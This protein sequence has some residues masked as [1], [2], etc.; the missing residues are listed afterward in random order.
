MGN[1][2]IKPFFIMCVCFL[3]LP[4]FSAFAHDHMPVEKTETVAQIADSVKE[5][6]LGIGPYVIGEFLTAEQAELAYNNLIAD[7]YA[8]T[9]KFFVDD[10]YVI[11]AEKTNMI[12]AIYKQGEDVRADDVKHMV[13]FLMDQF[14]EPTTMAH[15][16]IIYWAFGPD[17]IIAT[18]T[19]DDSKDTGQLD[20]LATVKFNSS[21]AVSPGMSNETVEETGSIYFIITSDLL[22]QKFI[23]Q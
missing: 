22:L 9:K 20:I 14:G 13:G 8:G 7:S 17:G 2:S 15:D 10:Y 23:E 6:K 18:Q 12:L 19:Y 21:M 5:L 16:K 4:A 11:V 3:L 1:Q